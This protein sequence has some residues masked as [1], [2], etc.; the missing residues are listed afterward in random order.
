[1]RPVDVL[2]LNVEAA[3]GG[4]LVLL[5]E[6]DAP[7]RVLPISIGAP[8]AIAIGL[9]LDREVPPRPLTHDLLATFVR[10]LDARIHH[11]EV[12]E[13]RNGTFHAE[14]AVEG[15][16]GERRLD[17]RPSDAIALALRVDAPVFVSEDVLDEAGAILAVVTDDDTVEVEIGAEADAE[18]E[19]EVDEEAIEAEVAKFRS[20]LDDLDPAQLTGDD[21]TDAT[22]STDPTEP[23]DATGSTEPTE[24][25][26]PT[27][28]EDDDPDDPRPG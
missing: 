28:P 12:T 14:L 16:T 19:I 23:T 17:S 22:E 7:H 26:D 1:M 8:E 9:A 15:P 6:H 13:L 24:S 11:V 5:R 21:P 20:L 27:E 4:P 2:G 25:T 10:D 3:N 18:A